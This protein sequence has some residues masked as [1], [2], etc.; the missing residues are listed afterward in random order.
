LSAHLQARQ[1]H[2][3]PERVLLQQDR[4]NSAQRKAV[5]LCS[6]SDRLGSLLPRSLLLARRQQTRN[7]SSTLRVS[8]F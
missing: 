3:A 1:L 8:E 6:H 5:A 2:L 7:Q 4:P